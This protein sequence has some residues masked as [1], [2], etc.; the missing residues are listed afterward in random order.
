V[1]GR[2]PGEA[3]DPHDGSLTTAER[4][5]LTKE[6]PVGVDQ[7]GPGHGHTAALPVSGGAQSHQH[8]VW[9][10]LT[11]KETLTLLPLAVLTIVFGIY[12]KPLLDIVG[13]SFEAVLSN[14]MRVVGG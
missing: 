8:D 5:S 9:S 6:R 2:A 4:D 11:K 13:P 3:P 10:D 12:P 7:S 1:F 14:A